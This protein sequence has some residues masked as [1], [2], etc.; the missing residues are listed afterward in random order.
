MPANNQD[1]ILRPS[2][3]QQEGQQ[4]GEDPSNKADEQPAANMPKQEGGGKTLPEGIRCPCLDSFSS[5]RIFPKIRRRDGAG[6]VPW[7]LYLHVI[8]TTG[9]KQVVR[10][11]R[12]LPRFECKIAHGDA[13][14][15]I[16]FL[17]FF[18]SGN[19]MFLFIPQRFRDD[20]SSILSPRQYLT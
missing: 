5:L 19:Q 17:S 7:W 10:T 12:S 3:S 2:S 6:E 13:L 11:V 18:W 15:K 1:H 20:E 8:A 4:E 16:Q 9:R 14:L